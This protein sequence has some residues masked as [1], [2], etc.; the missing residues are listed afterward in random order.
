MNQPAQQ[1]SYQQLCCQNSKLL[2]E[3]REKGDIN[4]T[5][6]LDVVGIV[7]VMVRAKKQLSPRRVVAYAIRGRRTEKL[8]ACTVRGKGE[9]ERK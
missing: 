4:R 9:R 1:Q 5:H 8:A 3:S 7:I 6:P 2:F